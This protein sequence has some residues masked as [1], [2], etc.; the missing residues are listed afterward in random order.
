MTVHLMK[1][2]RPHDKKNGRDLAVWTVADVSQCF[3]S[4]SSIRGAREYYVDWSDAP[5]R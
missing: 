3:H 5:D 2:F 1:Q 4:P